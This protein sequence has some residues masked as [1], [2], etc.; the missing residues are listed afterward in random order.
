MNENE[1]QA[2]FG[3]DDGFTASFGFQWNNYGIDEDGELD[4]DSWMRIRYLGNAEHSRYYESSMSVS[5]EMTMHACMSI[6]YAMQEI[7][8]MARRMDGVDEVC[9]FIYKNADGG[10][11]FIHESYAVV[12]ISTD[13]RVQIYDVVK[14]SN[15]PFVMRDT[16]FNTPTKFQ[17]IWKVLD[18]LA[19]RY[20]LN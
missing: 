12:T 18:S 14:M 13:D 5:V 7:Q 19:V 17:R 15:V 1:F 9:H 16:A 6:V 2:W 11:V 20:D 8:N 10:F 4:A 3:Y